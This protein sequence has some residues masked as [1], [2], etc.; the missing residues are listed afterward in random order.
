[1]ARILGAEPAMGQDP[2]VVIHCDEL[3]VR[4]GLL[5]VAVVVVDA[6]QLVVRPGFQEDDLL[7]APSL[8]GGKY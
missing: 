2:M 7:R 5:D 4:R 6:D 8:D 1:M 3:V